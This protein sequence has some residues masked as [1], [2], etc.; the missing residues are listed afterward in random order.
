[1]ILL[2][3]IVS[4][5]LLPLPRDVLVLTF[6]V[7]LRLHWQT[8]ICRPIK[9]HFILKQKHKKSMAKLNPLTLTPFSQ[10]KEYN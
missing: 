8:F 10:Q 6:E 3:L 1:M 4:S 5:T 9:A 2:S 7:Y